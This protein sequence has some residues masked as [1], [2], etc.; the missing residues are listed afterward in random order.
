MKQ[1]SSFGDEARY[2]A[3]N[4][5][6]MHDK[7]MQ[8]LDMCIVYR[9]RWM[10]KELHQA[11]Q[12]AG[13][14]DQW[15]NSQRNKK[16]FRSGEDSVKLMTMHSSK[17]LEFPLVVIPGLGFMPGKQEDLAAEAKL[18]YV[19]MTRSTEK[20]LLTCHEKSEFVQMLAEV[21]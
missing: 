15:L 10:G 18:L 3:T 5:R 7:G 4:L 14:P 9:S 11:L 21:G 8:W 6:R 19:A 20:L 12:M 1:L 17:G 13:I 2:I 16:S